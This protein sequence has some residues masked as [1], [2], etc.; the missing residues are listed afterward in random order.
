MLSLSDLREP[1][2]QMRADA[3]LF[4]GLTVTAFAG[5]RRYLR[6]RDLATLPVR[7]TIAALVAIVCSSI[8]LAEWNGGPI[9]PG[10]EMVFTRRAV[11]FLGAAALVALVLRHAVQLS[12]M[13]ARLRVHLQNER[14]EQAKTRDAA[15]A[16]RAKSDFLVTMSHELRT[17]LN[18]L[19]ASADFLLRS[20]LDPNQRVHVTTMAH[21]GTRLGTLLNEVLDLRKIEEGRLTLDRLPFSPGEI[22][23]EVA[24]LFAARAEEKRIEL[25]LDAPLP[26]G[27]LVAG[28]A[29]RFRQVLV[30]LVDNA[31]KFTA[32]G[33][34][35]LS[36]T[37]A[38]PPGG[39][40]IAA[41]MVRVRDTG[42]GMSAAQC[43]ALFAAFAPA[44]AATVASHAGP[45]L[46]LAIA[47][48]L[49]ALMGGELIGQ[50]APGEGTELSFALAVSP[51]IA[52]GSLGAESFGRAVPLDVRPRVLI[53]DDIA[54][55]R[56][57]LQMFL[58]QHGFA[59]DLA[60]GGEQAV[61]L[62]KQCRYDAIL[63]DL[64]MP[65][66]DGYAAARRIR[67]TEPAGHRALILAVTACMGQETRDRCLAAGMDE[68]FT[69]PLELRKFCRTLTQLL[70]ARST[71]VDTN[72]VAA[73]RLA[74]TS[75]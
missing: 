14:R 69:K 30:N 59:A 50:S 58:E 49:V 75:I 68:H 47:H 3:M 51:I 42:V 32:R 13:R 52:A 1:L 54:A 8:V 23:A 24:Q 25:K 44:G 38:A 70:A 65:D 37:Y 17:P 28:D 71:N 67:S 45:A 7:R 36:L 55:N 4:V 73:S 56:V 12:R 26:P 40:T 29:R 19:L 20:R 48:R 66:I 57:M 18:A 62:A 16:N 2:L 34:V 5:C 63:M 72:L 46:G 15:Q 39:A 41:L 61:T 74:P 31:V 9:A 64:N 21:E 33:S 27:L 60:N 43:K 53:V 22:A 10:D 35:T 6:I 11:V